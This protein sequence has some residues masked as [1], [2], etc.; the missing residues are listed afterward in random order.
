MCVYEILPK[1]ACNTRVRMA[2]RYAEFYV[3]LSPV[4]SVSFPIQRVPCY[5]LYI[6]HIYCQ[7]FAKSIYTA[8]RDR[9]V[10]KRTRYTAVVSS[11][12]RSAD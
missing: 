3:I 1:I 9:G 12:V 10:Y 6:L 8:T 4:E 2:H 11:Q 5:K 7:F